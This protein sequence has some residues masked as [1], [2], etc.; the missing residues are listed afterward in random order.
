MAL[1]VTGLIAAYVLVALLLLSINLYS[2]W[3]W[4]VKATTIV[5]VSG[6]YLVSY[7]SFSPILGWPTGGLAA[8]I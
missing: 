5:V 6:F 3:S 7:F 8:T 4:R 2:N 1:G